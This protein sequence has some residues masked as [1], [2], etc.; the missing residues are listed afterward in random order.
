MP[1]Y[2][3]KQ[4]IDQLNNEGV[5]VIPDFINN[6]EINE[7]KNEMKKIIENIDFNAHKK[8]FCTGNNQ[9]SI[10][11]QYFLDSVDKIR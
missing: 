2:N 9:P 6:D 11:D 10:L 3:F 4:Y 1:E 5:A 7:M 8:I